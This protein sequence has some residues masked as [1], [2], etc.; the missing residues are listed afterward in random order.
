MKQSCEGNVIL[1]QIKQGMAKVKLHIFLFHLEFGKM[2]KFFPI[3]A[4][5]QLNSE[6]RIFAVY[7]YSRRLLKRTISPKFLS[8][9]LSL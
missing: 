5:K 8:N 4:L 1:R 3:L 6:E 9:N 2:K 7:K